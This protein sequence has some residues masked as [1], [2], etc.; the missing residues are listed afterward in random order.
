VGSCRFEDTF[1]YDEKKIP[2]TWRPGD[3]ME[4][5]YETATKQSE[6]FLKECT[7]IPVLLRERLSL[8]AFDVS[9]ARACRI[10][11]GDP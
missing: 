8:A 3:S 6:E 1:R 7:R 5:L 11:T 4:A 10:T 2:R 9:I